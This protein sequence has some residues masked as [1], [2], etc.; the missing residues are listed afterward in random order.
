MKFLRDERGTAATEYA[1]LVA[2]IAVIAVTGVKLT[3]LSLDR[4]ASELAAKRLENS[5]Q[6]ASDPADGPI[7][8]G[9]IRR[10]DR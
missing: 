10:N 3:D 2:L 7:Y 6:V 8:T 5:M 4:L 9:S 1:V